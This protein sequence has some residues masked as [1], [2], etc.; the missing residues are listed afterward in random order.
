MHDCQCCAAGSCRQL[1][2]LQAAG[3]RRSLHWQKCVRTAC[4]CQC[5][6]RMYMPLADWCAAAASC[7]PLVLAAVRTYNMK[8]RNLKPHLHHVR[9]MCC[10]QFQFCWQSTLAFC[11]SSS[12]SRQLKSKCSAAAAADLS[13]AA[14]APQ[15]SRWQ[16]WN[17]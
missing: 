1:A 6:N 12:S 14:A 13:A 10:C 5:M 4:S 17:Q 15:R 2:Y 9:L 7:G 8:L 3:V 11:C 16:Q